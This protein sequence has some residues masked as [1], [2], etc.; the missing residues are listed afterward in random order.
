M[1]KKFFFVHGHDCTM[2][3][4]D[5]VCIQPEVSLPCINYSVST[6]NTYM[7]PRIKADI[8]RKSALLLSSYTDQNL[9]LGQQCASKR[10]ELSHTSQSRSTVTK[11]L[12]E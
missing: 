11:T 7:A 3:K 6:L 5:L 8:S 1:K 2:S 10:P 12:N 9:T 4:L